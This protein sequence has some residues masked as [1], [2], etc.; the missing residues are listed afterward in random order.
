M[1]LT[2][3][4]SFLLPSPPPTDKERGG[5]QTRVGRTGDCCRHTHPP[6]HTLGP[7]GPPRA[8]LNKPRLARPARGSSQSTPPGQLVCSPKPHPGLTQFLPR[9]SRQREEGVRP[10]P[11]QV[12]CRGPLPT[13]P[14]RRRA[15]ERATGPPGPTHHAG[16]QLPEQALPPKSRI[17]GPGAFPS[18]DRGEGQQGLGHWRGS[19]RTP[20]SPSSEP[21][22][23]QTQFSGL[24]PKSITSSSQLSEPCPCTGAVAES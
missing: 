13:V 17:P 20:A 7:S 23:P 12:D 9:G 18:T 2:Q 1:T 15:E 19:G 4:L 21:R 10:E 6:P 11:G 24:S 5:R 14:Q 3:N 16:R 8:A 22:Q